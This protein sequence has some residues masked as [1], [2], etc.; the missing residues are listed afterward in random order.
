MTDF[1]PDHFG[2]IYNTRKYVTKLPFA[3]IAFP[4]CCLPCPIS[5]IHLMFQ[6]DTIY[7]GSTAL[8]VEV[9]FGNRFYEAIEQHRWSRLRLANTTWIS[10]CARRILVT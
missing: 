5:R 3:Y 9:I 2:S 4:L 6:L 7:I 10:G 1:A 8:F